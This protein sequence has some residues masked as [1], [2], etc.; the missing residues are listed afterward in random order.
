MRRHQLNALCFVVLAVGLIHGMAISAEGDADL[1]KGSSPPALEFPHFP[2][3]L[4]TFVWRNWPLVDAATMARVL[5]TSVENVRAL[6]ESM[7]LPAA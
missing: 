4:H 7:G 2:D 5:D 6:A 3:R 1:P